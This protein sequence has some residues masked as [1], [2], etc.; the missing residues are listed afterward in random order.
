MGRVHSC[1]AIL[2]KCSQLVFVVL[3]SAGCMIQSRW[4]MLFHAFHVFHVIYDAAMPRSPF[5]RLSSCL[6]GSAV[7]STK[8]ITILSSW[9]DRVLDL[10]CPRPPLRQISLLPTIQRHCVLSHVQ[11]CANSSRIRLLVVHSVHSLLR[12]YFKAKPIQNLKMWQKDTK[13][14]LKMCLNMSAMTRETKPKPRLYTSRI[15]KKQ[16]THYIIIGVHTCSTL[17]RCQAPFLPNSRGRGF[18]C[19][20]A[21]DWMAIFVFIAPQRRGTSWQAL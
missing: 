7:L 1:L 15:G 5:A 8:H 3:A 12:F 19:I 17:T 6:A 13:W 4:L 21:S 9:K 10:Y 20:T 16:L 11:L 18:V 2:L 14:N